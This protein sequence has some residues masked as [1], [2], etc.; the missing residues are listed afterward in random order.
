MISENRLNQLSYIAIWFFVIGSFM[1]VSLQAGFHIFLLIPILF[2]LKD[3]NF[4]TLSK[5]QIFFWLFSIT[6]IIS[7]MVNQDIE[8]RGYSTMTKAKYY[9]IALLAIIPVQR[10]FDQYIDAAKRKKLFYAMLIVATLA[11]VAGLIA[12]VIGTNPISFRKACHAT[13]NCG[14]SG[15]YM[16]YSH[17]L[18]FFMSMMAGLLVYRDEVKKYVELKWIYAAFAFNLIALY[19]TFTRGAWLGFLIAIPFAFLKKQKKVVIY[20]FFGILLTGVFLFLAVPKVSETF[21]S[22]DRL[23]SNMERIGTWKAA[24]KAVEERP[25]FGFGMQNFEPHSRELKEKYHINNANFKGHAHNI[26]LEFLATTGI[27]GFSFFMLWLFFWFKEMLD[28]ADLVG[29]V[30]LPLIAAF[31]IA[32]QTQSTFVLADNT[33]FMTF[34]YMMSQIRFNK[35][36]AS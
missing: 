22:S 10:A 1:S 25:I 32:S 30:M 12:L 19:F 18:G 2:A 16:N 6:C 28:R 14:M 29:A 21:T 20:S 8:P 9:F 36:Y 35:N 7:V 26:F 27:V 31:V 24:L 34:M 23:T 15:M 13:R 5:S 4:K 33:F 17:N 3:F 11:G